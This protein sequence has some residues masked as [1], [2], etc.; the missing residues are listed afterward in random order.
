MSTKK[1]QKKAKKPLSHEVHC[2][3]VATRFWSGE[4]IDTISKDLKIGRTTV[5]RALALPE[6]QKVFEDLDQS[7]IDRTKQDRHNL[8]I[9][10]KHWLMKIRDSEDTILA[11]LIKA[12]MPV[13]IKQTTETIQSQNVAPEVIEFVRN[14]KNEE[15]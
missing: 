15:T 9:E 11:D 1:T 5:Y 6:A 12:A 2:V 14:F 13:L 7:L 10:F 4:H 3:D 8:S